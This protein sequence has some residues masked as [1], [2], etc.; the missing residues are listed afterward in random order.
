MAPIKHGHQVGKPSRSYESWRSM[1]QRC[2]NHNHDSYPRYGGAGITV[3]DRWNVPKGKGRAN[4]GFL[5]FLEDMGERP[6][7]KELDRIDSNKGYEPVN[8]RWAS[9]QLQRKNRRDNLTDDLDTLEL[10]D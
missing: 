7:G 8:V 6:P 2:T 9:R 1:I 3:C 10:M 4:V 5:N